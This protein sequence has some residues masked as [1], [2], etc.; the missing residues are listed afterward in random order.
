MRHSPLQVAAKGKS[1]LLEAAQQ[2]YFKEDPLLLP[3]E[4]WW[5]GPLVLYPRKYLLSPQNVNPDWRIRDDDDNFQSW[6]RSQNLPTIFFDGAS[7]GNPCATGAGGV[8]YSPDGFSKDCFS[9]GLG[10]KSNNQ[11]EILGLLK[12]CLIARDK[13]VKD[14]QVFGDSEI[15]IKNLNLET[16]FSNAS[17]NK[18]L[19][20]LKRVLLE[21]DTCKIYHILRKSN[22]DAD[23]MANKRS[24]IMKGL[25]IVNNESF[26]QMP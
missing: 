8:I 7:K 2:Q 14:L 9:W 24:T 25:L 11:A 4:K 3:K 10:Q 17:V 20:R 1:F 23:Q 5:P 22:S 19:D 21:F 12:A 6:W 16:L 13:G 18:I 26:V 15:I